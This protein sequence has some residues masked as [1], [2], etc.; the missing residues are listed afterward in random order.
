MYKHIVYK[1]TYKLHTNMYVY[2]FLIHYT[3]FCFV[4]DTYV[5]VNFLKIRK[6]YT[7]R[8]RVEFYTSFIYYAYHMHEENISKHFLRAMLPQKRD[9]FAKNVTEAV[10][11]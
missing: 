3:Y 1:H 9:L 6:L 10:A 2:T 11:R 8:E 7:E 5:C 4:I